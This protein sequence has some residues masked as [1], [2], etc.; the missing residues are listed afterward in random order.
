MT[1]T[2]V[3]SN[4]CDGTSLTRLDLGKG[5]H[6]GA[7]GTAV[8]SLSGDQEPREVRARNFHVTWVRGIVNV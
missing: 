8:D 2:E 7:P 3:G 4:V 5:K 1:T 6:H